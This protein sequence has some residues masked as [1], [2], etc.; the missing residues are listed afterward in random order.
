MDL[1]IELLS[2]GL[3][4]LIK[5]NLTNLEFDYNIIVDTSA[6]TALR[7]IQSV[8]QNDALSDFNAIEEI[9]NIFEKYNLSFGNRHDF[10]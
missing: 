3:Y 10:D 6:I 4:D 5:E 7:D 2:N 1:K 9:I 8:I